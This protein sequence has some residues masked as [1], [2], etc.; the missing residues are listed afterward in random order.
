MFRELSPE[1]RPPSCGVASGLGSLIRIVSGASALIFRCCPLIIFTGEPYPGKLFFCPK[2]TR[3]PK[4]LFG[5]K[6][7][8]NVFIGEYSPLISSLSSSYLLN[9]VPF[10]NLW[11][12]AG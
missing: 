7:S 2:L 3:M 5:E 12:L 11:G 1:P 10:D 6:D 8:L 9:L 4:P